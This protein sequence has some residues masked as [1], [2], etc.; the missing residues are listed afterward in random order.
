MPSSVEGAQN[1]L[2][3]DI[4]YTSSTPSASA[5][6]ARPPNPNQHIL[7]R[8][9]IPVQIRGILH[10]YHGRKLLYMVFLGNKQD[11]EAVSGMQQDAGGH[12]MPALSL[13]Q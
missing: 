11:R 2:T 6:H 9:H 1:L 12:N 8:R 5:T 3:A 7:L 4:P 10:I 13:L